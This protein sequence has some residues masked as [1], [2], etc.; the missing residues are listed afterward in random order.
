[1]LFRPA[2][3]R[4]LGSAVGCCPGY[5]P[6]EQTAS[7]LTVSSTYSSTPTG[8]VFHTLTPSHHLCGLPPLFHAED[9]YLC[10][11]CTSSSLFLSFRAPACMLAVGCHRPRVS[12]GAR[13]HA[14]CS[15]TPWP[16]TCTQDPAQPLAHADDLAL[17]SRT[18]GEQES[19]QRD[20]LVDRSC[21]SLMGQSFLHWSTPSQWCKHAINLSSGRLFMVYAT[22][23]L[24]QKR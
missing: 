7:S 24:L 18:L 16:V 12:T 1:M 20:H 11:L 22:T 6:E 3:S 5:Q 19:E 17:G 14:P 21:I 13:R 4:F 15:T 23:V 10:A 2:L 9:G 8:H